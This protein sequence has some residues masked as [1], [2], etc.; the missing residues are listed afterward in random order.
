MAPE[1]RRAERRIV[2]VLRRGHR[3]YAPIELE[4]L[5]QKDGLSGIAVRD[6]LWRLLERRDVELTPRREVRLTPPARHYARAV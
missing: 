6:A 5:L 1:I 4:E 2:T 3:P